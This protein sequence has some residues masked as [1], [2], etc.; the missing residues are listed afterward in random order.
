MH[1]RNFLTGASCIFLGLT[2]AT[3]LFAVSS[4]ASAALNAHIFAQTNAQRRAAGR[5]AL[6][7]SPELMRAAQDYA[8]KLA[9]A[10]TLSHSLGGT[11]PGKR[12]RAAGFRWRAIGENIV[13]AS[14]R[15]SDEQ[16]AAG[17]IR[18]WMNSSGHR[19]NILATK[20]NMIG[21]G[22]FQSNGRAYGVQMFGKPR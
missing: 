15:G 16:I 7:Q 8:R 12:A 1:R 18:Q 9:A 11:D 19:K 13:F 21:V 17:F 6:K 2:P 10:G 5:S 22:A 20:Y 4:G 3:E 14:A